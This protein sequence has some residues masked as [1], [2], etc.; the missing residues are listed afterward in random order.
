MRF[1]T[2]SLLLVTLLCGIG[3]A[4][5]FIPL[6]HLPGSDYSSARG[7]SDDGEVVAGAVNG[8]GFRWTK[9]GGI[10]ELQGL[11][12]FNRH[13]FGGVSGDGMSIVGTSFIAGPG[14]TSRP[15]FI[16]NEAD[17]LRQLCDPCLVEDV[18]YDGAYVVGTLG[19]TDGTLEAFR[20]SQAE[21]AVRLGLFGA[22]YSEGIR[23]SANGAVIAGT[24]SRNFGTPDWRTDIFVWDTSN[25]MSETG[26]RLGGGGVSLSSDGST[27]VGGRWTRG[28]VSGDVG[29][30]FE[31]EAFYWTEAGG[32]VGLGWL[33]GSVPNPNDSEFL[34]SSATGASADGS[35]IVGRSGHET[36]ADAFIWTAQFGMEPLDQALAARHG[37]GAQIA[38]WDL[39]NPW[40]ISAN[41]RY[42]VGTG[43]NPDGKTEA[44]LVRLDRP[45]DIATPG[46]T[47]ADG[48][49]DINDLNNVR[50]EF[51]LTGDN[52]AGDPN[53][54][55]IVD[56]D[57]L[58]LVR[59]NFGA[60]AGAAAV[61]EPASGFLLATSALLACCMVRR[62]PRPLRRGSR[63]PL[64][65][66]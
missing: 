7:V 37:L 13:T 40:D 64:P 20:W 22:P 41:G 30:V 56:I 63:Q 33:P 25:G 29:N 58:N 55:S 31:T 2:L 8:G 26:V 3:R 4:A 1:A 15:G 16:N 62:T 45:F 11:P 50:N 23:I 17:G 43:L 9:S 60:A 44:W 12:G 36:I 61:P 59:N 28:Y 10:A 14:H 27:I 54:D 53:G 24:T 32:A 42:I 65:C 46:D 48:I 21:G 49:V 39:G 47:D 5:E 19:G 38:G 6:G 18:S 57:D 35:I 34:F 51:G 52:L 66:I